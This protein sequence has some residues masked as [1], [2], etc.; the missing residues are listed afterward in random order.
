MTKDLVISYAR[1]I[2][3]ST[4]EVTETPHLYASATIKTANLGKCDEL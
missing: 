4:M 2:S 3:M 1:Y